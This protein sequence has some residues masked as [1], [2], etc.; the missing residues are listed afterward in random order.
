VVDLAGSKD[1]GGDGRASREG[2][3]RG[4]SATTRRLVVEPATAPGEPPHVRGEKLARWQFIGAVEPEP[5][6]EEVR[7]DL[8]FALRDQGSV[9]SQC[10]ATRRT[11]TAGRDVARLQLGLDLRTQSERIEEPETSDAKP[12]QVF[13]GS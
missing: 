3:D 1:A 6:P 9:R 13:C 5:T 4:M 2:R 8:M 12:P 7:D 10:S 11:A